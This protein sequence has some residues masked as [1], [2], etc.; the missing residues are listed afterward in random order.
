MTPMSTYTRQTGFSLV[1]TLIAIVVLA[2]GLISMA[3]FQGAV[4]QDSSLAK[5]RTEATTQGETKIDQLRVFANINGYNAIVAGT[6]TVTAATA[7]SNTA[8]T[9]AWTVTDDVVTPHKLL[10]MQVT[11]PDK[12]GN[13]TP[14]TTATLATI[15]GE[16][17]PRVGGNPLTPR[18]GGATPKANPNDSSDSETEPDTEDEDRPERTERDSR[19]ERV[20]ERVHRQ[21]R[22]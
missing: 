12:Q 13:V 6:D 16:I 17:D 9:R 10:T 7:G 19:P 5:A 22:D 14:D 21:Q 8:Y 3:R 20:Q 2:V 18:T 15:I 11:W 4:L 1:E